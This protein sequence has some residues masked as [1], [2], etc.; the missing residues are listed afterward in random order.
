MFNSKEILEELNDIRTLED[1]EGFISD[2]QSDI[3]RFEE[4]VAKYKQFITLA[5]IVKAE[6]EE[7]LQNMGLNIKLPILQRGLQKVA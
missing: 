1:L 4:N 6:R 3:K 2:L 7:V 5:N